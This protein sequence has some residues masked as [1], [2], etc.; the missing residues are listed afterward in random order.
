M[1]REPLLGLLSSYREM[2]EERD[3][4]RVER[5]R[6]LAR[7]R[8][9]ASLF[10]ALRPPMRAVART[11]ARLA[12]RFIPLRG[13]GKAAFLQCVD[14]ARAATWVLGSSLVADGLIDDPEDAFMLTLAELA[15]PAPP[16]DV[17]E[18]VAARRAAH[19]EYRMLD[20]PD[21]FN[22]VPQPFPLAGGSGVSGG[23]DVSAGDGSDV[24]TGTPVSP[25]IVD[26]VA[27]L[28]VD[29][30]RDDPIEPGEILVCR[31]TDPS[32]AS[33]MMLAS[34][35]VIDIGGPI[36]HGA[37]VARELGIPCVIGTR[38]GSRRIRTGD[39]LRVDGGRG[40]V[41]VTERAIKE[42]V[43]A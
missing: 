12:A 3:P 8:A 39:R 38:D 30:L 17:G 15:A 35:L 34:A 16:A 19:D 7:S 2:G 41:L 24:V 28:V 20:V 36:S 5:E 11:V 22:G 21:L 18:L 27:R 40:E 25:G 31:T 10:E 13:T 4:R 26:G 43:S 6:A 14:V 29:P 37:I 42:S 1:R 33:T 23:P 32:W 9:E